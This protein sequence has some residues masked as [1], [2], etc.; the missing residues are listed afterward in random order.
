MREEESLD[1]DDWHVRPQ[2]FWP[3]L[4]VAL[5]LPAT[6]SSL[7][8]Q[9]LLAAPVAGTAH[10]PAK[11]VELVLQNVTV[12]DV[13]D[14]R[15]L[16]EHTVVIAG[17]RIRAV[18]S[19]KEVHV[20]S[21]AQVVDGRGKYLIPGL[22]DMHTHVEQSVEMYPRFIAHGVTG[23][24]EMAQRFRGGAEHFRTQQSA[25]AAGTQIGPRMIGPSVDLTSGYGP[26]VHTPRDAPRV[27]DSLKA[28][29][30]VFLKYHDW[31]GD[32]ATFFAIARE[33]R[34]VGLPLVGHVSM[35]V[36]NVAAAD[37]GQRSIEHVT[38][39]RQ[40]WRFRLPIVLE[41]CRPLAEAYVRNSTW[42]TP[43]LVV[44][45]TRNSQQW[46]ETHEVWHQKLRTF[47]KGMYD[48][49]V[50]RFLA[51]SDFVARSTRVSPGLSLLQELGYLSEIGL[52][53]LE[54]LQ[55]ATLNPAQFVEATDSLGTIAP[56]KLADLVLLDANPLVDVHNV[57][58]T[59]AVIANGHY[60][61]RTALDAMNPAGLA[62]VQTWMKV[63]HSELDPKAKASR[64]TT[65]ADP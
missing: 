34:R 9:Q 28:A 59:L 50:R 10:L 54:V 12:I 40:C 23:I 39:H 25:I 15:L 37:S 57:G 18:G 29:G 55:T 60:F 48:F 33:A 51:G 22:W 41:S 16:P 47:F 42:L 7:L 31:Q 35:P 30:M 13:T 6:S 61:D 43:T 65:P 19:A 49:G 21:D 17:N 3:T 24:R 44:E 62:A 4:V 38:E 53:P 20:P 36:G 14:G 45:L 5:Y 46:G 52:T 11:T 63:P 26:R 64:D 58:T 8:A 1:M 56:G 32:P 2:H 27:I